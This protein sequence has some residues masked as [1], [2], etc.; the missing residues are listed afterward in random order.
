[1]ATLIVES[2]GAIVLVVTNALRSRSN[3]WHRFRT[4]PQKP[5]PFAIT[6]DGVPSSWQT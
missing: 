6:V 2:I 1:M 5:A 4:P 3:A